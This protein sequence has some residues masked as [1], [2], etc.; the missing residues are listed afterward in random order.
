[1]ASLQLNEL[2][3]GQP[4]AS[5]E[6]MDLLMER[7]AEMVGQPELVPNLLDQLDSEFFFRSSPSY[8][9]IFIKSVSGIS[10]QSQDAEMQIMNLM[11]RL[12]HIEMPELVGAF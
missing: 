11:A 8:S 4:T 10:K 9:K 3:V 2:S 5:G 7:N 1:M 12:N 6:M